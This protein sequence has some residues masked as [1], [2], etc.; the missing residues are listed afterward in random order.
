MRNEQI[1]KL[2]EN[3]QIVRD[4]ATEA[5]DILQY[6]ES[7]NFEQLKDIY[8]RLELVCGKTIASQVFIEIDLTGGCNCPV[9]GEEKILINWDEG[10]V[11]C[12]NPKCRHKW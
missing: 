3:I 1:S 4:K 12:Q 11:E 5:I 10:T 2:L 9:C 7:L 6:E 8:G